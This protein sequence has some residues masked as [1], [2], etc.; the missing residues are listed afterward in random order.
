M[1]L[2][3]PLD[4]ASNELGVRHIFHMTCAKDSVS[5]G[6]DICPLGLCESSPRM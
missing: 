2:I 5:A 4:Q 3:F 1:D 6:L